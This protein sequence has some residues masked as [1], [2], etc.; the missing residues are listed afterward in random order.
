MDAFGRLSHSHIEQ[1]SSPAHSGVTITY[2]DSL[3][4]AV[5]EIGC[6]CRVPQ[7]VASA[8]QSGLKMS[9]KSSTLGRSFK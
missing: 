4:T 7:F 1:R 9:I 6:I 2:A 5:E 3:E 8:G